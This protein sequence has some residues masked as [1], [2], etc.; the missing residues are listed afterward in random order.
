MQ[1]RSQTAAA[2]L[3]ASKRCRLLELPVELRNNIYEN[4]LGTSVPDFNDFENFRRPALVDT[5]KTIRTETLRLYGQQL[6]SAL[7]EGK[8]IRDSVSSGKRYRAAASITT[9]VSDWTKLQW[10]WENF[11]SLVVSEMDWVEEEM[12][13]ID[14]EVA[15]VAFIH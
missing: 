6:E 14:E 8:R 7:E 15:K 10:R 13:R 9:A 2:R 11:K 1:T 3:A 5:C 12:A 4:T